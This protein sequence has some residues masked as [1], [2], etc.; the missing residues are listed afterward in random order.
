VQLLTIWFGANDAA[1]LP[2][3]QHVPRDR[4]KANLIHL[5]NMV[6]CSTSA[7]YSPDTRIIL[8]TPP[9][10]NTHQWPVGRAFAETRSYA[11]AVKEVGV[12]VGVPVADVWTE[13]WEAAGR[14]ERAL[15]QFLYDGLHLNAAGYEVKSSRTRASFPE[16]LNRVADHLQLDY[17][18]HRG[19]I[20]QNS[21]REI[22]DRVHSVCRSSVVTHS[23]AC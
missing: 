16:G 23:F 12:Q 17:E 1:L 8:I 5:V 10:V 6:K 14:D 13:I 20:P 9:P 7:Y 3:P 11:E 21:S 19:E 15:E 4:Y 18:D 22:A 2:S